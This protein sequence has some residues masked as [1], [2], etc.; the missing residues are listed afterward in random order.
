MENQKTKEMK[1]IAPLPFWSHLLP[2]QIGSELNGHFKSEGS[3]T[4]GSMLA[5][6]EAKRPCLPSKVD[7]E[8]SY[9]SSESQNSGLVFLFLFF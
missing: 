7:P 4:E 8:L 2:P 6:V 1:A 5:E 9:R 3:G